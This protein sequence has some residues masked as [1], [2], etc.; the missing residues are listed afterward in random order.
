[1]AGVL[2]HPVERLLHVLPNGV[3]PGLD[4]HA[5]AHGRDFGQIGR[6][7]HL[8][9]PLR[10]IF[11]A[12]GTDRVFGRLGHGAFLLEQIFCSIGMCLLIQLRHSMD[13]VDDL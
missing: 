1:M 9:I 2:E 6:A 3:A 4:D 7:H 10:I 11:L 12:R 13:N 5:A 8:L